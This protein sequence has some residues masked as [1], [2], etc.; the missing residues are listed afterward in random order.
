MP[1]IS[2]VGYENTAYHSPRQFARLKA[3]IAALDAPP[4]PDMFYH[5][6]EQLAIHAMPDAHARLLEVSRPALARSRSLGVNARAYTSL[7]DRLAQVFGADY[8]ERIDRSLLSDAPQLVT[9]G[10]RPGT[11]LVIV[12]PTYYN[13]AMISFPLLDLYLARLGLDALYLKATHSEIAYYDGFFGFGA[14]ATEVSGTLS[15]FVTERGYQKVSL[16]GASSGGFMAL[17]LGARLGAARVCVYG[18]DTRPTMRSRHLNEGHLARMAT[19]AEITDLADLGRIG[20]I[21]AYAGSLR[22]RDV[23]CLTL[24]EGLPNVAGRMI[25]ATGHMVLNRMVAEGYDFKD[26][27]D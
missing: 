3:E 4:P 6:V 8:P 26:L 10:D 24:L 1:P 5:Y 18:A 21:H 23:E 17:W 16:L 9:R 2:D 22:S 12:V 15:K 20:R 11:H 25:P 13:N 19:E 14:D 27:L 7:L